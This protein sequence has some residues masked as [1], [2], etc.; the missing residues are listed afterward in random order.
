MLRL[1]LDGFFCGKRK[2]FLK[3]YQVEIKLGNAANVN[4]VFVQ[5]EYLTRLYHTELRRIVK[6]QA[7]ARRLD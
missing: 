7:A 2:I 5:V 4:N 1:G 6:I 3:Y